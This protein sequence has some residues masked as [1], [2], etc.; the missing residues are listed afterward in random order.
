LSLAK[1][2]QIK[3]RA[4][5]E[6]RIDGNNFPFTQPNFANPSSTYNANAAS[7]FA[8]GPGTRGSFSD[9]GTANGHLLIVAR[10]QF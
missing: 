2:W 6:L 9:V 1:W 3:E 7:T 8:K 5:F 4:R 10:F